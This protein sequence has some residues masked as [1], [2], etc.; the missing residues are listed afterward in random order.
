MIFQ[1]CYFTFHSYS[2]NGTRY[3]TMEIRISHSHS[4][5]GIG[6][7]T[8]QVLSKIFYFL[9]KYLLRLLLSEHHRI[10]NMIM[11][12]RKKAICTIFHCF[13]IIHW[14]KGCNTMTVCGFPIRYHGKTLP[15]LRAPNIWMSFQ[16]FSLRKQKGF[17]V[18]HTYVIKWTL[19]RITAQIKYYKNIYTILIHD[20]WYI[21][22]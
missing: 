18:S 15:L 9:R 21:F 8:W 5:D 7:T 3:D 13:W 17:S 6:V 11:E 1:F 12:N 2:R 16:E 22:W 19:N 14:H 10:E 4:V 20:T